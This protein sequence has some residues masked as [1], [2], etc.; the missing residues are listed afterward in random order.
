[1]EQK[2]EICV[3]CGGQSAEHEIS[4][5]SA[6]NV[7]K[8]LDSSKYEVSVAY[9]SHSGAWYYFDNLESFIH[10]APDQQ[11]LCKGQP[12]ALLPG[13]PKEPLV[14]IDDAQRRYRVDCVIPILHGTLGEDGAPQGLLEML[15]V[16]YVGAGV[17]PSVL[18]M[19]KHIAKRLLHH[20]G[21]PTSNWKTFFQHEVNEKTYLDVQAE[22][23]PIVFVK[24][25]ALGSSVG[26]SKVKNAHEFSRAVMNAFCYGNQIIVE[27]YIA[28]REIEV[29]V[30]GNEKPVAAL[31][32][33]IIPHHE[34]YSYD[35]KYTDPNGANAETPAQL[36]PDI[37]ERVQKLA[38][39]A[40]Q[41]LQCSGMARV[42][43]FINDDDVVINE[44]NTIPGFS[45]ISL[46]P[47]NWEASGLSWSQLFDELIRLALARHQ[48]N[49][50]VS[51]RYIEKK[52]SQDNYLSEE[53]D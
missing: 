43:F 29:S 45:D 31:P 15:N 24:P 44:V 9:I 39:S 53:Q 25:V 18:C 48:H 51:K 1:M 47:K 50:T 38:V 41:V 16:P 23:G 42:D 14:A 49:Q 33:E 4:V 35:A 27:Q 40:F 46:Y 6:C 5:L 12:V 13:H 22:L 21:L 8:A 30:L 20:A 10:A 36:L 17:S 37:I 7:V 19:E 2:L 26:I 28:G 32:G 52:D 11:R 3:L 34:F